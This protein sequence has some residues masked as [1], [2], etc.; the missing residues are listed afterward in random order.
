MSWIGSDAIPFSEI[1]MTQDKLTLLKELAG[2]TTYWRNALVFV[3]TFKNNKPSSMT[4]P[5]RRWLT[6]IMLG[7][8]DELEKRAWRH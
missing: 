7:L 5:Q 1:G 4:D 2:Y 8:D 6:T 3:N